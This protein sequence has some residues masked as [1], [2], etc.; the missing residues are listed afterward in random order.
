MLSE[1]LG[2]SSKFPWSHSSPVKPGV[3]AMCEQSYVSSNELVKDI[4]IFFSSH[5]DPKDY[6]PK[7]TNWIFALQIIYISAKSAFEIFGMSYSG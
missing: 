2:F 1:H 4:K 5:V 3:F 6:L 7:F